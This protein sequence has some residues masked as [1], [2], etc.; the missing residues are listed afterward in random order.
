MHQH[1]ARR[2]GAL[3]AVTALGAAGLVASPGAA[4]AA[5]VPG[6]D[7]APTTAAAG[8]LAGQLEGGLLTYT[9]GGFETTDVGL[10]IDTALA[11]R[12]VG[13]QDAAVTAVR[14]AV[15]AGLDGYISG[16]AFG[17]PGSTYSGAA[18]KALVLATATGGDPEA[19]GGTDLVARVESV[20]DDATGRTADVSQYGDYANTLG[21]SFAA[22]G[23]AAAGSPEAAAATDFLLDQQCEA[24]FFR[25]AFSDADA[26]DQTCDGTDGAVPSVDATATAVLN[27]LARDDAADEAI[28]DAVDRA[29]AWLASAQR[30]GGAFGADDQIET[31]NANSTGLAGWALG[32]AG[33]AEPAERAAAWLRAHQLTNVGACTP[34]RAADVGAVAYDD[35]ALAGARKDGVTTGTEGQYLRATAQALPALQWAPDRGMYG[36]V[37]IDRTRTVRA[38]KKVRVQFL[39]FGPGSKVCIALG[40]QRRLSDVGFTGLASVD[41]TMP[42]GTAKRTV[43]ATAED[44]STLRRTYQVL[45]AT[46]LKVTAKK[47]RVARGAVQVVKVRGLTAREPVRVLVAGRTVDTGQA[48]AKGRFTARFKAAGSGRTTVAVQG[49]F[50]NRKGTATY[51]V[52]R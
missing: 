14:D 23:L 26:A 1:L 11:L 43:T 48:N 5:P 44:G 41:L 3:L 45:D 18:G 38:G 9:S 13:G 7:P 24:G 39:D 21:Q 6:A 29:A 27:L 25:Q 12:E 15:A 4:T 8:W 51:R 2:T 19:F 30:P 37:E 10:S 35:G 49:R 28:A 33:N 22:R 50:G 31:P 47:Q 46:R 32:L 42:R 17:D 20:T 34:F 40:K 36:V 16:D 52:T